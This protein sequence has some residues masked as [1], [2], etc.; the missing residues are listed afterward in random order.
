MLASLESENSAVVNCYLDLR[1]DSAHLEQFVRRQIAAC[2]DQVTAAQRK[3]LETCGNVIA[4]QL[5]A[6]RALGAR[7]LAVFVATDEPVRL[8]TAMPFAVSFG[9]S[10]TLSASPDLLP[11]VQ[12]KEM[13][14]RFS[15]VVAQPGGLQVAEVDLGEVSIKLWAANPQTGTGADTPAGSAVATSGDLL[16]RK[17]TRAPS[18][19]GSPG[20]I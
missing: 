4:G 6:A 5:A 11:L 16:K 3:Y 19:F 8:L 9:D 13:Y 20:S 10:L 18:S 14:G 15:V 1:Q 2:I 17:S 12:L 7:G